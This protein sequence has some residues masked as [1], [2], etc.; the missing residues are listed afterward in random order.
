MATGEQIHGRRFGFD[1][2]RAAA[3]LK[4]RGGFSHQRTTGESPKRG[5]MVSDFG[6]EQVVPGYASRRD[7]GQYHG[8][9]PNPTPVP[10]YVGGWH[11]DNKT[12]LDQSQNVATA[13][14]AQHLGRQN[15]QLAVYNVHR[16]A[17]RDVYHGGPI[18][19][20]GTL[21]EGHPDAQ[22]ALRKGNSA[23]LRQRTEAELH[24]HAA[25]SA[26]RRHDTGSPAKVI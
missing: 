3:E 22:A 2:G 17:V 10:R 8:S 25:T 24:V 9:H 13:K 19:N 20:R 5:W 6:S 21:F 11:D 4:A 7:I 18:D 12:Y 15:A 26:S 14:E 23:A 16:E 1:A